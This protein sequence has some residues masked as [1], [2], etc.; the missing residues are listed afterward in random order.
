MYFGV[1]AH[2]PVNVQIPRQY[3]IHPSPSVITYTSALNA[4]IF[5][6][7]V[8]H[9]LQP[10]QFDGLYCKSIK[11]YLSDICNT[12]LLHNCINMRPS[13]FAVSRAKS[14]NVPYHCITLSLPFL[15]KFSTARNHL[16]PM[17]L[18]PP[19]KPQTV[20]SSSQNLY[21]V[22]KTHIICACIRI[23]LLSCT[24]IC[25]FSSYFS[26][27]KNNGVCACVRARIQ[28][29]YIR[30]IRF[31]YF[32]DSHVPLPHYLLSFTQTTNDIT[33]NTNDYRQE[34]L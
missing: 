1:C 2:S 17:Q 4:D 31:A 24:I 23:C 11:L 6:C 8:T 28:R 9:V 12:A 32:E 30:T 7:S 25:T 27:I 3:L 22:S 21:L 15:F 33:V 29:I 19:Y 5:I 20:S 34:D 13:S 16:G 26:N 14:C 18:T 10:I